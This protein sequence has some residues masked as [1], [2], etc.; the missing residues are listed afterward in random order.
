MTINHSKAFSRT[1]LIALSSSSSRELCQRIRQFWLLDIALSGDPWK[2]DGISLQV[3]ISDITLDVFLKN[4]NV[5]VFLSIKHFRFT[6]LVQFI[7]K[8]WYWSK[9]F[10]VERQRTE[11]SSV[12]PSLFAQT[13]DRTLENSVRC[14]F[15]VEPLSACFMPNFTSPLT[16][17]HS[18]NTS[19]VCLC[20]F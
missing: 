19:L 2:R 13:N 16:Q 14:F 1:C 3:T 6:G 15:T 10:I 8:F 17:Y 11:I 4:V 12:S 18:V 9:G 7:W 5:I 20:L